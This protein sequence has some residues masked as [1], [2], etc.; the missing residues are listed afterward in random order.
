MISKYET[1]LPNEALLDGCFEEHLAVEIECW[2]QK[3]LSR[4]LAL[5][6]TKQTELPE[7]TEQSEFVP[8]LGWAGKDRHFEVFLSDSGLRQVAVHLMSSAAEKKTTEMDQKIFSKMAE[9]A[10]AD[11]A[12][13]LAHSID[14]EI[15][16]QLQGIGLARKSSKYHSEGKCIF[17]VWS[18]SGSELLVKIIV[19]NSKVADCRKRELPNNIPALSAVAASDAIDQQK[20]NLGAI[21][22]VSSLKLA[23]LQGLSSGDVV[24]LNT[25][26]DS[27]IPLL[28]NR[29]LT[30]NIVCR[31]SQTNDQVSLHIQ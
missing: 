5:T 20:I 7:K 13:S 24:I 29:T 15:D 6:I 25:E 27:D 11:L 21:V 8:T 18:T 23:E 17:N 1:W 12:Y 10:V 19:S 4:T 14:P 26:L 30:S 16:L 2:K 31:V 9:D 28:V 22:G 3:W